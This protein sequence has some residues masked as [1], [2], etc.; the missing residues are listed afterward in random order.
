MPIYAVPTPY[1]P[2]RICISG[3][4]VRSLKLPGLRRG[5]AQPEKSRT[6]SFPPLAR[7]LNH[8]FTGK[9]VSFHRVRVDKFPYPPFTRRVLEACS[10]IPYGR[11]LSYGEL[12]EKIGAPR[13]ARAVG[14]ALASNRVPVIVP[15]HR[16]IRSD[17]KIGRY[18][19]G[20]GWKRRLLA[21]EG[22]RAASLTVKKTQ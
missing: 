9:T 22:C 19:G 7:R 5:S 3:R 11:T 6:P 16:V 13:A 18:S 17:G 21:M 10:R 8:Y 12:A 1:G 15:C 14:H 20:A 2:I 4:A